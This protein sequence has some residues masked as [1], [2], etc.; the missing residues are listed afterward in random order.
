MATGAMT[1]GS[2]AAQLACTPANDVASLAVH[3]TSLAM[4]V[5]RFG[6]QD[7][8]VE[9]S[10]DGW[11]NHGHHIV[12][13]QVE[14][15]PSVVFDELAA[16]VEE[17]HDRG[18]CL[19]RSAFAKRAIISVVT[20]AMAFRRQFGQQERSLAGIPRLEIASINPAD[21]DRGF[22]CGSRWRLG[23]A[24]LC[25]GV[26]LDRWGIELLSQFAQRYRSGRFVGCEV[27]LT[28]RQHLRILA[29][30]VATTAGQAH[31]ADSKRDRAELTGHH[32]DHP[33][34]R[35]LGL[36]SGRNVFAERRKGGVH[37]RFDF[38]VFGSLATMDLVIDSP[39]RVEQLFDGG[40]DFGHRIG[41]ESLLLC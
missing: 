9:F 6:S 37:V 12:L 35:C 5:D 29:R 24:C 17:P 7:E 23:L 14:Q 21:D 27:L 18:R 20:I 2:T 16:V 4:H 34:K 30:L 19:R 33:W 11:A 1:I 26:R 25:L 8:R 28:N 31:K 32:R 39:K 40:I 36:F 13:F 38:A 41:V 3:V 22:R 10:A 15:L